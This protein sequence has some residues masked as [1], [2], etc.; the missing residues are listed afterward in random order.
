MNPANRPVTAAPPHHVAS[1]LKTAGSLG[2]LTLCCLILATSILGADA[3][4]HAAPVARAPVASASQQRM[5]TRTVGSY[6]D[7]DTLQRT[8]AVPARIQAAAR[9]VCQQ[10]QDGTGIGSLVPYSTCVRAALRDALGFSAA[11]GERDGE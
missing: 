7:V 10:M 8:R 6:F 11:S 5:R 4:G 1:R 3:R 2:L 9:R